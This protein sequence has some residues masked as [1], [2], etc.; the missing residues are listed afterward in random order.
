VDV[1]GLTQVASVPVATPPYPSHV[2]TD[3]FQLITMFPLSRAVIPAMN[4]PEGRTAAPVVQTTPRSWAETNLATID[5]PDGGLQADPEQGDTPGPVT[6]AAAVAVP[7]PPDAAAAAK[8]DGEEQNP[9]TRLVVFGDSDFVSN[10]YLGIEGNGD[11]F[12]N[13]VN[14]LAQQESLIAIRPREA[15]DRRLTMTAN[16]VTGMFWLSLV[17]IPV[18][19]LG[20]GILTWMRRRER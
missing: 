20:A 2:I 6:I 15:A 11:L 16:H 1:S 4:A 8:K 18:G 7:A 14:W 3:R 10:N 13:T 12:M 19:V 9:E 5:N 17:V